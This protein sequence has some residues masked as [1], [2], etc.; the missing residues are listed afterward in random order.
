M[1]MFTQIGLGQWLLYL[2]GALK[3][4]GAIGL[5]IP[6]LAGAAALD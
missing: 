3:F 4:A 2:V 6:R 5:L 1:E